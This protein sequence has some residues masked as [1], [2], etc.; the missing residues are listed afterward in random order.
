MPI[1]TAHERSAGRPPAYPVLVSTV[2]E[3]LTAEDC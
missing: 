1:I 2:A 3:R